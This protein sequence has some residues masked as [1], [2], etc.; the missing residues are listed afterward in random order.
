MR[1]CIN[2][3]AKVDDSQLSYCPFCR[4]PLTREKKSFT[5]RT[6]FGPGYF[7]ADEIPE[8]LARKSEAIGI[9]VIGAIIAVVAPIVG[10][11]SL[12]FE[13]FIVG[14]LVCILGVV[15]MAYGKH[16]WNKITHIMWTRQALR[17]YGATSIIEERRSGERIS[18]PLRV[19]ILP[20]D[21]LVNKKRRIKE[22]LEKLDERLVNGEIKE[23]T[24]LELKSKY[25]TKLDKIDSE[26]R[27]EE[28]KK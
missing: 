24:Y 26:I 17:E 27:K 22:L 19:E 2:C 18:Q 15:I 20:E 14:G 12:S 3:G 25:Q 1:T 7:K 4:A 21:T 6:V 28:R 10:F 9:M 16:Q 8:Y 23:E 11:A 13:A 5:A